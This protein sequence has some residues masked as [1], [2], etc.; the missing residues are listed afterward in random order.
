LPDWTCPPGFSIY[1]MY[2]RTAASSPKVQAFLK[3]V[4]EAFAEFDPHEVTL[5]HRDRD[6]VP[7]RRRASKRT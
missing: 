4:E 2:R 7:A 3:F 1:A 6:A 5:F